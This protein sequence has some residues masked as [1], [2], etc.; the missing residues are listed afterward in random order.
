VVE[1]T[2]LVP[3]ALALVFLA[4]EGRGERRRLELWLRL[5]CSFMRA[6]KSL[7]WLLFLLALLL[8]LLKASDPG[9]NISYFLFLNSTEESSPPLAFLSF[10]VWLCGSSGG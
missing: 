3:L 7:E 2:A 9:L 5:P 6:L 10:T 4:L 8:R 1:N